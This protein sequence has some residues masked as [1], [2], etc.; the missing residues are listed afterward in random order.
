M[1]RDRRF[2][3]IVCLLLWAVALVA[4][5][6]ASEEDAVV[7]PGRTNMRS[8]ALEL[9]EGQIASAFADVSHLSTD[10][11]AQR[12]AA[13]PTRVVLLD[14]RGAD[15]HAISWLEGAV[16]VAPE[17][18]RAAD[19]VAAAGDLQ[20]KIVVAYC[21]IGLRSSRLIVRIGQALKDKGAAEL[22]N[23]AGGVFRWRNEGRP[24]VGPGGPTHTIH[25]YNTLW[26]QF[27]V[28]AP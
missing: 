15:E 23:L 20:G 21:P 16:H 28:E 10:D 24:L 7:K 5:P 9:M 18:R 3:S 19:V 17:T 25:P 27:L 6:A 1:A 14:V 4:P 26:R 8:A 11:F 2:G 22:H 13:D 12:R